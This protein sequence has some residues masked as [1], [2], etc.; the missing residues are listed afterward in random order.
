MGQLVKRG[1]PPQQLCFIKECDY[2][3]ARKSLKNRDRPMKQS[4]WGG[5]RC[6][7]NCV[8]LTRIYVCTR[9]C[10]AN[11]RTTPSLPRSDPPS[12]ST[13][14]RCTTRPSPL[15][16]PSGGGASAAAS[17]RCF[18]RSNR[19]HSGNVQCNFR[20]RS[21][22]IQGTFSA[23]SGNVQCTFRERSVQIPTLEAIGGGGVRCCIPEVFAPLN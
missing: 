22:H 4:C 3:L 14:R 9:G 13:L 7:T 20:E 5:G 6:F 17:P 12:S 16:K 11:R 18:L 8:I 23:H 1:P 2:Y 15:W 10:D 19:E 21:V